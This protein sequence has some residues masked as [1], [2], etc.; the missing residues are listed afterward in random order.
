MYVKMVQGEEQ[1]ERRRHLADCLG[2]VVACVARSSRQT[3]G[4]VAD[5][6]DL[7]PVTRSLAAGVADFAGQQHS[8]TSRILAS[9][10]RYVDGDDAM[11]G[12]ARAHRL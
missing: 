4:I 8:A 12:A 2:A 10:S 9:R 7:G 1:R 6:A 11:V 5:D 3:R